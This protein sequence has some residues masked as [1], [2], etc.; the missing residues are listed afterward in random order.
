M[1]SIG[2]GA[3]LYFP[4]TR[5]D[6][7]AIARGGVPG[8]RSAVV[9]LEDAVAEREVGLAL[10]RVRALLATLRAGAPPAVRLYVR[11]RTPA[12]LATLARLPGID[13]I[14]GFV[15]PKANADNLVRWLAA[16]PRSE[17]RL[18][19][20]V[21]GVE[22]FD[23]DALARLRDALAPHAERVTAVRIGGNDV[24]GLLG[25]R[26]SR[27][28]TAYEGPLGRVIADVAGT[29]LPVGLDVAAPVFEHYGVPDVLAREVE[30]DL[31]HGLLTKT[32]IHPS[33]VAVVH[34][35]CRP[36]AGELAD[37]RAILAPGAP[38]VFGR[39]D[40][41]CEPATH[42]GWAERTIERA[43]VHG[44]RPDEAEA[45]QRV[46]SAPAGESGAPGAG[47]GTVTGAS[48]TSSASSVSSVS[49]PVASPRSR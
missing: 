47:T 20:T 45:P 14:E 35:A 30:L 42:R 31:E 25:T 24:L 46:V 23:R 40:G 9:C 18:M 36:G 49:P 27:V 44:V 32:A 38:A 48:A 7:A 10:G 19:P 3:T 4:A 28:R 33:Q 12:M 21:E 8:L 34:A 39:R 43:R 17:H 2:L 13:A 15:L 5:E 1:R 11:P 6:L 16:L 37:A 26:R 41:L 22:A 29:F